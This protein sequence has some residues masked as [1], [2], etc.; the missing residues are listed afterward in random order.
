MATHAKTEREGER[1]PN[2]PRHPAPPHRRFL[3][4]PSGLSGIGRADGNCHRAVWTE[5][6]LRTG[7]SDA[8]RPTFYGTNVTLGARIGHRWVS[9]ALTEPAFASGGPDRFWSPIL[10]KNR[11]N[12]HGQFLRVVD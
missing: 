10:W 8:P 1:A 11:G 12:S 3:F 2:H 7:A 9:Q 6:R 4:P 5:M